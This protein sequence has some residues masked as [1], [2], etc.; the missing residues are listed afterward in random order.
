MQKKVLKSCVFRIFG[1]FLYISRLFC[2]IVSHFFI[3]F[4]AQFNNRI[5][6]VQVLCLKGPYIFLKSHR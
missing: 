2:H 6:T 4:A 3:Y 1:R 5:T